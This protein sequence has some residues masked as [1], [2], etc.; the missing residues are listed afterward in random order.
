MINELNNETWTILKEKGSSK[1]KVVDF[2]A[3]WCGPCKALSASLD[4]L[5]DE[6][7]DVEF[8]KAD[9]E[10][11]IDASDEYRIRSVPTVFFIKNGEIVERSIGS[12]GTQKLRELIEQ[13][14]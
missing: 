2:Y 4:N 7:S 6:F 9:V 14:K 12:S 3:Q 11:C 13:N 10:E 1:L 5:C 8:Y